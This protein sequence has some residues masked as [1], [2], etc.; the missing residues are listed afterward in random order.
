MSGKQPSKPNTPAVRVINRDDPIN[1]MSP[2]ERAVAKSLGLTGEKV[3]RRLI[4][5]AL[6]KRWKEIAY[7]IC[8][9]PHTQSQLAV[10]L[11]ISLRTLQKRLADPRDPLTDAVETAKGVMFAVVVDPMYEKLLQDKSEESYGLR[12]WF[13]QRLF[14]DQ[15]NPNAQTN[16]RPAVTVNVGVALP[17]PAKYAEFVKVVRPSGSERA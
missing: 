2:E 8:S 4:K 17:S 14:P 13:A 3:D 6:P 12:Q 1:S 15:F 16:Q 11:G 5:K 7:A 10:A 9:R